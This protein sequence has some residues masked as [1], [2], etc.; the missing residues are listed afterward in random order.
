MIDDIT[1]YFSGDISTHPDYNN[2]IDFLNKYNI[3]PVFNKSRK[4]SDFGGF[5][6][7]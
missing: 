6:K 2:I 3:K 7:L 5:I 1:L 4:L